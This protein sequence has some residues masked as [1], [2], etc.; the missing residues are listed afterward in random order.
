MALD[1]AF[2]SGYQILSR[3]VR[4]INSA[5]NVGHGVV[6]RAVSQKRLPSELLWT[7]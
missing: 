5:S 2:S 7:A 3:L 6:G 4:G 1:L